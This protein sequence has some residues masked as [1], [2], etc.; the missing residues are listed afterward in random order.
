MDETSSKA[1]QEGLSSSKRRET[2][3]WVASLKPSCADAFSHNSNPIK[4]A[5]SHYFATCPWD[6]IHGNTDDLSNTFRELAEGADLLGKSIYEIK[7]SWDEPEELKHGNYS[8]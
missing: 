3:N 1:S 2:P 4:E 5:R 8:L 7:L 6:W